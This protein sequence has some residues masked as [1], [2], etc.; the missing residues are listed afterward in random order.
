[1]LRHRI[2]IAPYL[3]VWGAYGAV[4]VAVPCQIDE[5][6]NSST[7]QVGVVRYV[8]RRIVCQLGVI[9]P[10]GS[11]VTLPDG[12]VGWVAAVAQH[13]APGLPVPE[14]LELAVEAAAGDVPP[15]G[16]GEVVV[17]LR[18]VR[19]GMDRYRNPRYSTQSEAVTAAVRPLSSAERGPAQMGAGRTQTVD[20][21]E[22]IFA[23]GTVIRGN[24][25]MRIRGL[26]YEV[27][28]TPTDLTD[29][30][31]GADPGVKVIGKRVTG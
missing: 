19:T 23:A 25:R 11:R 5:S 30:M 26:T 22:V 10:V 3:G 24:D 27:D 6:I 17:I 15:A 18:R 14:H 13:T 4:Q 8:N 16:G 20:T 28:G 29:S 12:L 2:A 21:V 9:V 7:S 31:S 1:M